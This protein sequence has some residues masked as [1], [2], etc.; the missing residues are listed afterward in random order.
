MTLV[1]FD[2]R[3]GKRTTISV[4]EPSGSRVSRSDR[5]P[6]R[7]PMIGSTLHLT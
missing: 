3:T 5:E 1:V 6:L 7:V 4:P 2:P